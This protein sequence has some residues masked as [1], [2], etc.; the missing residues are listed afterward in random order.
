M[1]FTQDAPTE[2]NFNKGKFS[3]STFAP[4]VNEVQAE[5]L[6]CMEKEETPV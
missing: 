5:I 4:S 2:N 3:G 6:E 1:D